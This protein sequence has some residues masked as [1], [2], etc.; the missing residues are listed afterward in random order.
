QARLDAGGDVARLEEQDRSRWDR[1]QIEEGAGLLEGVLRDGALGAYALQAAIAAVHARA[2]RAEDTAWGEIAALYSML[3]QVRPSPVVELNR[4][5]AVAMADGADYGLPLLD[6]L[7]ARGELVDYHL[8]SAAR[9][10]LFRRAGRFAE[11]A[12]SYRRAISLG[13][14]EAE[15]RFLERRL[16]EVSE[17]VVA[18]SE[19][20]LRRG[21]P[22]VAESAGARVRV[23]DGKAFVSDGPFAESK[24]IVGGF[25]IIEAA[26]REEAIEIA[27][28]CP[29]ARHGV[30]EVHLVRWRDTAA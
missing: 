23:R 6:A 3:A 21:A 17:A 4:A 5:I 2:G 14:N 18:A 16:R 26:S 10:D 9:G 24:E 29:H 25:W 1:A 19:G 7:E 12:V 13:G 30:V 11:A 8:L 22:L 20:K 28:R 27:R 15:R